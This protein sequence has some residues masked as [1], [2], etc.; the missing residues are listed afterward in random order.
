MSHER[1]EETPP[2]SP[3][4]VDVAA[5]A[6]PVTAKKFEQLAG[7]DFSITESVGGA[8]GLI[9][10]TAPGLVFVVVFVIWR[11]LAPALI[12]SLIVAAIAMIARLLQRTP[13][14]QA[15]GGLAGVAIGAVWAHMSGAAEDFFAP[16]LIINASY[17]V[18]VLISIAVGWP[19]VGLVMGLVNGDHPAWRKNDILRR[20]YQIASALWAAMFAVRLAVQLPLYLQSEAAWLGAA[21]LVMGVPLWALILWFTWVLAGT[22]ATARMREPA[23]D[24]SL[25]E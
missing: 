12:S 9:E 24:Q 14:T 20:R 11:D 16:G 5:E 19:I 23:C 1:G 3:D 13:L 6:S 25:A 17:L 4:S 7:S 18:G 2:S 10:S 15:I 21:R 8:R 22:K